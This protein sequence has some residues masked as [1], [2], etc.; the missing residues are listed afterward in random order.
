MLNKER[1]MDMVSMK[2]DGYTLQEIGN[3][4]GVSKQYVQESF[5]SFFTPNKDAVR[6]CIYPNLKKRCLENKI[7]VK[8]LSEMTGVNHTTIRDFFKGKRIPK[9]KTI[10]KMSEITGL[11]VEQMLSLE[12]EKPC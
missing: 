12:E 3:K 1:F 10:L 7:S 8:Q 2:F 9:T 5:S 4:Y 11:T 6:N